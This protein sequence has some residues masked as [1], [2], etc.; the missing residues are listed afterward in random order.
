MPKADARLA[1]SRSHAAVRS[2]GRTANPDPAGAPERRRS[3]AAR[4]DASHNFRRLVADDSFSGTR[5]FLRRFRRR[6]S[7]PGASETGA[8]ICRFC[9]LETA[10]HARPRAGTGAEF[11]EG[12]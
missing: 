12:E 1:R 11:L 3:R 10:I 8:A 2:F 6:E 7:G 4:G 5:S 9:I